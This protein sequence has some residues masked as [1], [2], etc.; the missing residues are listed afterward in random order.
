MLK[1][2]ERQ[3]FGM[4]GVVGGG[5]LGEYAP[6]PFTETKADGQHLPTPTKQE[7]LTFQPAA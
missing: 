1:A 4:S 5:G 6:S 2:T 7:S 3:G